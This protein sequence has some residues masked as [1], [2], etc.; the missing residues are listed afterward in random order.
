VDDNQQGGVQWF[1]LK[2]ALMVFLIACDLGLNSSLEC[3]EYNNSIDLQFIMFG[4]AVD[5]ISRQNI[6]PKYTVASP[7][8]AVSPLA[9]GSV[10]LVVQ[11]T[12]FLTLFLLLCDTFLFQVGLLGVL[13][14][15]FRAVLI[16]Q[17]IYVVYTLLLDGYRIVSPMSP[18]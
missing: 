14:A 16:L 10:H 17:P 8:G 12:L 2:L 4:Y 9:C 3:D 7:V 5:T 13:F 11:I 18:L 15:H 1:S 6:M